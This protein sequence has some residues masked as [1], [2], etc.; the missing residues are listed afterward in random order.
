[1]GVGFEAEAEAEAGIALGLGSGK[2]FAEKQIHSVGRMV[3]AAIEKK[4]RC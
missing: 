3:I 4:L 1:V 2:D